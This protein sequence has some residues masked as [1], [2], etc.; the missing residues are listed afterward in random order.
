MVQRLLQGG[1][2]SGGASGGSQR[3]G[4]RRNESCPR[5]R[6]AIRRRELPVRVPLQRESR[7]R[8]CLLR[9]RHLRLSLRQKGW[10]AKESV[11]RERTFKPRDCD[12]ITA[13]HA[14]RKR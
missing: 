5:R 13:S 8:G 14:L 4:A 2:L 7:I 1:L 11:E 3:T 10:A 9:I 12:G 6:L